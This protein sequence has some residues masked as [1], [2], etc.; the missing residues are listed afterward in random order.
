M[1]FFSNEAIFTALKYLIIAF[2]IFGGGYGIWRR[3]VKS[4]KNE[5]AVEQLQAEV[6]SV[7]VASEEI[8]EYSS[9]PDSER[10]NLF[11]SEFVRDE[12]DK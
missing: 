12:N 1:Q 7:E 6:R 4:S 5:A 3:I 10:A 11:D 9:L 8:Q 2:S